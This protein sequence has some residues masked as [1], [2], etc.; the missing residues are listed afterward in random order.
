MSGPA[1]FGA[2]PYAANRQILGELVTILQ[3]V[4]DKRKLDL[5]AYRSR[6][7]PAGQIHELMVTD[8][9]IMPGMVANRVGL[10]GFFV[11]SSPGVA[12]VGA[13]VEV[14]GVTIGTIVGFNDTHMPNH[15]NIC[16]KVDSI[17][18][19]LDLGLTLGGL[20]R[21]GQQPEG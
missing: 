18:D 13:T 2:N 7:F 12:L 17:G 4:T 15:Q 8:E 11:V 16:V 20:V 19:G 6:A 21:I 1:V 10:I 9:D 14:S 3:G 5:E